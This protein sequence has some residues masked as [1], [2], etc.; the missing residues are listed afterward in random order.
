MKRTWLKRLLW[1]VLIAVGVT[2]VFQFASVWLKYHLLYGSEQQLVRLI[3]PD[4][5]QSA[6]FSVKYEGAVSWWPANPKP[7]FYI[8][9]TEVES[10][11]LL[12]RETDFDWPKTKPYRSTTDSF[13]NLAGTYAPWAESHFQPEKPDPTSSNP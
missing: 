10:G 12:L 7:H 5:E 8:T 4:G 6:S 1:I 13:T 11:K 9:V 2:A 3:S